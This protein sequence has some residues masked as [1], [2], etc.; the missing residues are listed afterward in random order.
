MQNTPLGNLNIT[1]PCKKDVPRRERGS[2][3][4]MKWRESQELFE[5]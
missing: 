1:S 4:G 3:L 5:S 2:A